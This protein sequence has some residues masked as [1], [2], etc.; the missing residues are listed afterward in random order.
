MVSVVFPTKLGETKKNVSKST[1]YL[2]SKDKRDNSMLSKP[3]IE[4]RR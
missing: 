4:R 1:T 3:K 2:E